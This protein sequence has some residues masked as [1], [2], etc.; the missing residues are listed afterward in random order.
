[1]WWF[2]T[3]LLIKRYWG[4]TNIIKSLRN[5]LLV[6]YVG[7]KLRWTK[8]KVKQQHNMKYSWSII[9][10]RCC[11]FE[12]SVSL[13][14]LLKGLKRPQVYMDPIINFM[15]NSVPF[16]KRSTLIWWINCWRNFHFAY[17]TDVK[18]D[19]ALSH[20]SYT[21]LKWRGSYTILSEDRSSF[22][23]VPVNLLPAAITASSYTIS[24]K[25]SYYFQGKE[26]CYC[27]VKLLLMGNSW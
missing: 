13:V 12:Y 16:S 27:P 11:L 25:S 8:S 6:I 7:K 22:T 26:F 17:L 1:M 20:I 18:G 4:K 19:L 21:C 15:S 2:Q 3:N 23:Q 24:L 9:V 5:R 10:I 14:L